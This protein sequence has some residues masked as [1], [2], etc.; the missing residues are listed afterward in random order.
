M[1]TTGLDAGL[2]PRLVAGTANV[3]ALVLGNGDIAFDTMATARRKA[4]VE[5]TQRARGREGGG[6]KMRPSWDSCSRERVLAS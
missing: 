3:F 5:Q 2:Y 4:G 1:G 6:R